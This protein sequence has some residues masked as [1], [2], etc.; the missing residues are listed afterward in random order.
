M[1]CYNGTCNI[2]N[3]PIKSG[4]KVVVIPLVKTK[5]NSE[6]NV[7]Y[8]TDV[9][10]PYALPLIGEYDEYG[11]IEN[12]QTPVENKNHLLHFKYFF[13]NNSDEETKFVP[14]SQHTDFETFVSEIVTNCG[15]CFIKTDNHYLHNNGMAELNFMMIHYGVYEAILTEISNRTIYGKTKTIKD[16][17]SENIDRAIEKAKMQM[18]LYDEL[19]ET[20]KNI[21]ETDGKHLTLIDVF[22]RDAI[23][24]VSDETFKLGM[25]SPCTTEWY[26]LSECIVNGNT[27][28]KDAAINLQLLTRALNSLRK[29]YLCDSGAGSQSQET[30]MHY[31]VANFIIQHIEAQE[32]KCYEEPY[33]S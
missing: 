11:S 29:G 9:F 12:I 17:I 31:V 27:E 33:F 19:E 16:A 1:G 10:T 5:Q 13:E 28:I 7:C 2:T 14:A 15:G 18:S 21:E 26:D 24:S 25:I 30:K 20:V 32:D 22:K 6:F 3:L 4:D 23:K 8:P